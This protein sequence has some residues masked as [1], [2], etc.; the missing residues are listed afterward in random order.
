[1]IYE[2][3]KCHKLYDEN[4]GIMYLVEVP[5][6]IMLNVFYLFKCKNCMSEKGRE[7]FKK[8]KKRGKKSYKST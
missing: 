6:V 1:M 2:C 8:F 3:A 4:D 5:S 7:E